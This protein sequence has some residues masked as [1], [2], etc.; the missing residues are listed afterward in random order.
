MATNGQPPLAAAQQREVLHARIHQH[1]DG[2]R[3][4]QRFEALADA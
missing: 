4:W 1:P 3:I 2:A